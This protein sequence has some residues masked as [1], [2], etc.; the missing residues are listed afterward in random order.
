MYVSGS[1]TGV[2]T[3]ALSSAASPAVSQWTT[4]TY[5]LPR[6]TF[7]QS[8][9]ETYSYVKFVSD[10]TWLAAGLSPTGRAVTFWVENGNGT[11]AHCRIWL[12]IRSADQPGW[13]AD[14]NAPGADCITPP[15]KY[16]LPS[17]LAHEFGHWWVVGDT[18]DL[19]CGENMDLMYWIASPG[20]VN[21][22]PS[23]EDVASAQS[24]YDQPVDVL[25]S[26]SRSDATPENV[27]LVWS[28]GAGVS[29]VVVERCVPG[30]GWSSL[31]TASIDGTGFASYVDANVVPGTRYGY[32]LLLST[33][34][35]DVVAGETWVDVPRW[36]LT[37]GAVTPNPS[38]DGLLRLHYVLGDAAPAS[39]D[40]MDV[41]GRLARH[42]DVGAA[43]RGAHT[44]CLGDGAPFAAGLY[45]VRLRQGT[46]I[47]TTRAIVVR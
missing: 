30:A 25:A 9:I 1:T 18:Y 31:G 3:A 46:R 47:R 23:S 21:R 39:L 4:R 27:T 7:Y 40:V 8:T 10:Q 5:G 34:G 29:S 15:L 35:G 2:T 24:L 28:L 42:V 19:T 38:C 6:L 11:I 43:G 44:V 16:D 33:G 32:R 36:E 13:C 26:V 37:L 12:R 22:V 14:C 20:I 41:G 17:I 45:W